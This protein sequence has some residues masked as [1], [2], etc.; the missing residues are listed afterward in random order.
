MHL[1]VDENEGM[2]IKFYFENNLFF[3]D[4]IRCD[5]G[6]TN[7]N[8]TGLIFQFNLHYPSR[9]LC[10]T[11][12]CKTRKFIQIYQRFNVISELVIELA[13]TIVQ[14]KLCS[15]GILSITDKN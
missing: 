4:S 9:L 12:N 3:N 11:N 1:L 5:R 15:L 8:G 6:F 14:L 7:I 13:G 10:Q 2:L